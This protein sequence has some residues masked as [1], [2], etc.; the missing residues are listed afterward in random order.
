VSTEGWITLGILVAALA[1]F[2]WGRLRADVIALS[3]VLAVGLTGVATPSAAFAGFGDPTVVTIATLFVLSA[4]LERTGVASRLARWL[5]RAVGVRDVSLI[6]TFMVLA[7]ILS[8]VMYHMAAMAM[9]LPVALAICRETGLSASRL[10]MPLAIG[11]RLG[12]GLTLIGK[13]SNLIVSGLLVKAGQAP[14]SFFSFFP[15]GL[16]M[17]IVGIVFMATGG[18][19]LLPA[20]G[21][22]RAASSGLAWRDL[23]ET[24]QLP[25]RLFRIRVRPGSALAGKTLDRASLGEAF[26]IIVLAI[27]R[28]RRRIHAPSRREDLRAGDTLLVAARPEALD[29]LRADGSLAI[30]PEPGA[31]DGVFTEDEAGLAEVVLAPRS[32]LAGKSLRELGFRERY[33]LNVVAIWR[34]GRSHRTGLA[35]VPLRFGDAL[36]VQGPRER[37][38]ELGQEPDFIPLSEPPAMRAS[39]MTFALAG[40]AALVLLGATGLVP[41]SLAA[42]LAAGVVVLGGCLSAEEAFRAVDWPTV[43]V[44]GSLLPLGV[45]LQATGAAAAVADALLSL[46]GGGRFAAL[47]LIFL[48]QFAIGQVVPAVPATMLMGPIALGAA[49]ALGANAVPFMIT[50]ASATSATLLTPLSHP[51]SLMVMGPGGYRFTDY[52]RVGAPLAAL[53]AVTLLGVVALLWPL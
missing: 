24:Y 31:E 9:L 41:I 52:A 13:P 40:V 42:L 1:G 37:L 26:G 45:A 33:A 53:L 23:H 7:G 20:R 36:L 14:L 6:V 51:I 3:T 4:G 49:T 43:I 16:A 38:R 19:R 11:T 10:L 5:V 12:G 27:V 47:V 35:D 21:A 39:R 29:R 34:D 32:E 25:Q 44:T 46:A 18:R 50:V 48:G 2:A 15:V 28:G 17:L 30:E 22:G 8:S